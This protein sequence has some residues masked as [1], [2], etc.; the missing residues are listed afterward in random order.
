[1]IDAEKLCSEECEGGGD[2]G[3]GGDEMVGDGKWGQAGVSLT[4][5]LLK[6]LVEDLKWAKHVHGIHSWVKG[7]K[8]LHDR[9]WTAGLFHG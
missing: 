6:G 3:W 2:E 4:A 7:E 5:I 9:N 1:M 8:H